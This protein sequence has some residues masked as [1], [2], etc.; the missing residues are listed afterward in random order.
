MLI[1]DIPYWSASDSAAG[2]RRQRLPAD[3][4]SATWRLRHRAVSHH[5]RATSYIRCELGRYGRVRWPNVGG[6]AW[7]APTRW[8]GSNV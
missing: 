3:H 8:S 1:A 2:E 6:S 4:S 7:P 5:K